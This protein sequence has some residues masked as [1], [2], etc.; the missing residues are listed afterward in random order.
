MQGVQVSVPET[1]GTEISR[2]LLTSGEHLLEFYRRFK[3]RRPFAVVCL[4]IRDDK[5]QVFFEL[6][7]IFIL[8]VRQLVLD[9]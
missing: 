6:V 9:S 8:A 4:A 5:V 3:D 2:Y 7:P 1:G